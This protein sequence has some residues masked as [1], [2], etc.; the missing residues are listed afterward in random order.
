MASLV[1][2]VGCPWILMHWRGHSADMQQLAHYTDVVAFL[3][4]IFDR[5]R[6]PWFADN[7]IPASA[8]QPVSPAEYDR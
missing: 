7:Y 2:D 1:A 5:R 8:F 4:H 3:K 6:M